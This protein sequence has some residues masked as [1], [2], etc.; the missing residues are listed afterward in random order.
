VKF[1]GKYKIYLNEQLIEQHDFNLQETLTKDGYSHSVESLT[2]L[3]GQLGQVITERL[4][5]QP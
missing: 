5:Q 4:S 1:S 3:V 2:L